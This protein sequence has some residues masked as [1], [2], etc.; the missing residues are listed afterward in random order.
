MPTSSTDAPGR[1]RGAPSA[2]RQSE[3]VRWLPCRT[4]SPDRARSR[5]CPA[6]PVRPPTT[7]A[8]T[9]ARPQ[10][11][12]ALLPGLAPVLVGDLQALAAYR[13]A[14]PRRRRAAHRRTRRAAR[15]GRRLGD[16]R[17]RRAL[18]VA[19]LDAARARVEQLR[20]EVLGALARRIQG[21]GEGGHRRIRIP[22]RAVRPAG[23]VVARY[24]IGYRTRPLGIL[25]LQAEANP[26]RH[27]PERPPRRAGRR[28]RGRIDAPSA[29]PASR[30]PRSRRESPRSSAAAR[31]R[32]IIL[33]AAELPDAEPS[34]SATA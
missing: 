16:A 6:A 21:E 30:S 9:R 33:L 15:V 31:R 19:H 7:G 2:P 23:S 20:G 1:R 27:V 34:P 8:R 12:Q 26:P 13:H 32:R 22:G 28:A 5:P 17:H 11:D 14:P 18:A 4:P 3:V 29:R 24:R 25:G 10:A